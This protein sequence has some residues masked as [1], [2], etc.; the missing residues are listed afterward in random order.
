MIH[1]VC[2]S[3]LLCLVT[4]LPYHC[5][6]AIAGCITCREVE[7]GTRSNACD[8][9]KVVLMILKPTNLPQPML[10][11]ERNVL[12]YSQPRISKTEMYRPEI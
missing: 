5:T 7:I 3:V 4:P 1:G 8:L 6:S 2:G 12:L 9:C 11:E 10:V